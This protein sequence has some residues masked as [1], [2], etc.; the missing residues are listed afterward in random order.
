MINQHSDNLFNPQ[1][2]KTSLESY[3]F[4]WFD[5]FCLWYPPGWLIIFNRHWQHYHQDPDGWNWL[6]YGLFLIPG[7]FYLALFIRWLRLGCRSPRS[8]VGEFDP[9]YQKAFRDEVIAPIIKYYFRGELQQIENLPQTGPMIVAMN[10]AGMCFP[11][12]FLTLGYLLSKTRG[13]L[14]QPLTGVSLFDHPW[15]IWWLPPG[16]SKVMGGVR[17]E[18]DDFEAAM[19]ER[20]ILLYAPEGL[21]GPKK[22]WTKRYQL[23]TFNSSFIQLSLRY[24]VPILPVI[25]IG[26]ENL[27]PWTLNIRKLQRLFNLPFLP[28]SPLIPLFI[29]FPS[30]GVWAM[31]SRLRYF[32]QP[33]HTAE[34][35]EHKTERA[36]TYKKAQQLREKLQC[37]MNQLLSIKVTSEKF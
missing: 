7:G 8:E 18:L 4:G 2:K 37:Q 14:V 25:C 1:L 5:W 22:G 12:D 3:K 21:R 16:W 26:N 13:W 34:L 6:E 24:Q 31:R 29:L 32:V 30:M 35:K 36:E 33:L 10:H 15:V 17:A 11:W 27:H 19:Q 20:K 9:N 23:E 28:I